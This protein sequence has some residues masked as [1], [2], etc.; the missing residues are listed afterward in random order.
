MRGLELELNVGPGCLYI[1]AANSEIVCWRW[2]EVE[3]WLEEGKMGVGKE[4][5]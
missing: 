2:V 3:E 5:L 4:D 1:L